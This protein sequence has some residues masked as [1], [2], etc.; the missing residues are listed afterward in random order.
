MKLTF[1]PVMAFV[2]TWDQTFTG[3]NSGKVGSL[4]RNQTYYQC[5]NKVITVL[6]TGVIAV[7][8]VAK[9]AVLLSL[10][11]HRNILHSRI[12]QQSRTVRNAYFQAFVPNCGIAP[13][14]PPLLAILSCRMQKVTL[15][16]WYCSSVS[17]S[18]VHTVLQSLHCLKAESTF[19]CQSSAG[20]TIL[21]QLTCTDV[22]LL[23]SP[24]YDL[25]PTA[26][27]SM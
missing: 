4:D 1:A 23:C 25:E 13:K 2:Y 10:L 20:S 16:Q 26:E 27:T 3:N 14:V 6:V 8:R 21:Y 5:K 19:C 7:A 9:G 22:G 24:S 11:G 12:G 18:T 17:G 15:S